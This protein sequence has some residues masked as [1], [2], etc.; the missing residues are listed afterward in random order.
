MLVGQAAAAY[1][2]WTGQNMPVAAVYE[3]LR[4][5]QD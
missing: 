5:G 3:T 4:S 2:Q 1:E